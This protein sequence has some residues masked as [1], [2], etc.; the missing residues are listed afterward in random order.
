MGARLVAYFDKVG[1]EFGVKGRMKLA[2]LTKIT[3]MTAAA[4]TDSVEN[5]QKFE[6]AVA[7]IK[8]EGA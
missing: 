2:L 1:K 4:A 6:D 8:R 7:Q 5:V 3:S